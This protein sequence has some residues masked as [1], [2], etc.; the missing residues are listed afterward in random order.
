MKGMRKH[1]GSTNLRS[2]DPGDMN[3]P[4]TNLTPVTNRI[5]STSVHQ[6]YLRVFHFDR[7]LA[8]RSHANCLAL[9]SCIIR[10]GYTV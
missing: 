3:N 5:F 4:K 8:L 2:K 1:Q 7:Q 9:F 6:S 10:D